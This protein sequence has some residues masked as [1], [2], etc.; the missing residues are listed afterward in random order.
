MEYRLTV[1][2]TGSLE[3]LEELRTAMREREG[4]TVSTGG[5]TEHVEVLEAQL[6]E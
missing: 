2:L 4:A 6:D 3:L 1:T 5:R